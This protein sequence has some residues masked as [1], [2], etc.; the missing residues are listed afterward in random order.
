MCG[1]HVEDVPDPTQCFADVY[2]PWFKRIRCDFFIQSF[3]GD[4]IRR[5]LLLV[6]FVE[7]VVGLKSSCSRCNA[8]V[9]SRIVLDNARSGF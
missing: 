8:V 1:V 6:D 7:V 5:S 4:D 3:Q 2:T 9:R